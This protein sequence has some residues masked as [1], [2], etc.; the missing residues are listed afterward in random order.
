[1]ELSEVTR[2]SRDLGINAEMVVREYW[3][4]LVLRGLS[5]SGIGNRLLFK[6]GNALRLAYGSPRFSD[7]LDFSQL[8][9]IRA[10]EFRPVIGRIVHGWPECEVTDWGKGDI[11]PRGVPFSHAEIRVRDP[12]L[13]R[14]FRI[15]IEVSRRA[16]ASPDR[17]LRLLTSPCSPVSVLANVAG[18]ESVWSDKLA[19]MKSRGSPRDSFDLWFLS[20]K[21]GRPLP[22]EL[23][24]IDARI[25][26]RDLRKYLPVGYYPAIEEIARR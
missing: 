8:K 2:I 10:D 1:M 9:D 13:D 6:G 20:Q 23:P 3:E 25:L 26:R 5:E 4:L 21:L 11:P 16:L 12:A 18:L 17:E 24:R 22:A 14:S 15:V 19:A 7:D